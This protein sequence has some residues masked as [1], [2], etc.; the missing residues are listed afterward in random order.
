[1]KRLFAM[2]IVLMVMATTGLAECWGEII[3]AEH[4]SEETIVM[5]KSP[6]DVKEEWNEET[7]EDES[8]FARLIDTIMFW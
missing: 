8:W 6:T 1:M 5:E 4:I 2:V 3:I 7:D